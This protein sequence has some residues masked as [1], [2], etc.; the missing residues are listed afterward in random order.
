[1]EGY[2]KSENMWK[3]LVVGKVL[4]QDWFVGTEENDKE[5]KSG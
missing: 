5:L 4:S 3:Q 2:D 1:M